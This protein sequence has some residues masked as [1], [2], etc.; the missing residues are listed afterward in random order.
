[1]KISV[2]IPTFN[3]AKLVQ[4]AIKSVL[5]QTLKPY[6]IIV[7]D[8]GST[9]DTLE[10]LKNYPIKVLTQKNKGIS[11]ARNLGIKNATGDIIALLDSDDEWLPTK[12]KLQLKLFEDGFSFTHTDEIWI[13]DNQELKQKAHHKK[14][15]GECFYENISFCKISPSTIMIEK[16]LFEKVGYFDED[17]EVCEDFDMW[18]R[19]LKVT[20]IKL[21][22][23]PLTK[24]YAGEDK[25]LSFK[26]FAMDRFRIKALLKH[27]PDSKIYHEIEKKLSILTY[28]AKKHQ[29]KTI[30]EFALEIQNTLAKFASHS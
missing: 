10:V 30:L 12:L 19:V 22:P 1:V 23:I 20:P 13:R 28:G 8:D 2:I 7:V 16:K 5:N 4:R 15:D 27:L 18:L 25:Q 11:S 17:L 3:R 6:E 24:K 29:N 26:Y 21:L 9:D 14:P